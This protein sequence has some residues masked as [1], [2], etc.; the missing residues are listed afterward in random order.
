MSL[1]SSNEYQIQELAD[2]SVSANEQNEV[3]VEKYVKP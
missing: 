3:I 1:R 2:E